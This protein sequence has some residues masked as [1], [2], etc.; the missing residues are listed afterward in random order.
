MADE[1]ETLSNSTADE[2]SVKNNE[3]DQLEALKET[4]KEKLNAVNGSGSDN[5][6]GD[7]QVTNG[8]NEEPKNGKENEENNSSVTAENE[9]TAE[10]DEDEI[11]EED[12]DGGG[13]SSQVSTDEVDDDEDDDDEN[14][15]ES[16]DE[17]DENEDD[18]EIQEVR[19]SGDS[20]D[21]DVMEVEAEDPLQSSMPSKPAS[22]T[23]TEVKKPQVVTIDD[24]KALQALA[25]SAA[26]SK[27]KE[28]DKVTIIDTSVIL[29]GRSTSGVT[30]TPASV[31]SNHKSPA[32]ASALPR[33]LASALQASGVTISSKSSSPTPAPASKAASS[34]ATPPGTTA[35]PGSNFVYDSKGQL[36]DPNLTDDTIVIE[37]P[38]FIV[39]YVYEK[40]PRESFDEFKACIKK[41][42]DE[43]KAKLK[44]E[45]DAKSEEKK[46]EEEKEREA[47]K[48]EK[49]KKKEEKRAK[50]KAKED[51]DSGEEDNGERDSDDDFEESDDSVDSDDSDIVEVDKSRATSPDLPPVKKPNEKFFE[52]TLGK[53]VMD[54]GMNLVQ[55]VVQVDLLRQQQRKAKK[56]K[57]AAVMHAIMSLKQNI[58][59]SKDKNAVF[60]M[61]EKKCKLCSFRTESDLALQHHLETPHMKHG[62]LRCNFCHY[63]T[64]SAQEIVAHMQGFH[65]VKARLE[66][67]PAIHQCPQC[68]FEDMMKGK[69]TRHKVGCDKRFKPERNCE[70]PHDFEPP[71]KIPK[72]PAQ[73]NARGGAASSVSVLNSQGRLLNQGVV[74]GALQQFNQQK[75]LYSAMPTLQF[76]PGRGRPANFSKPFLPNQPSAAQRQ[77]NL[78][79]FGQMGRLAGN[80][81]VTIQV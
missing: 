56:D 22:V 20:S 29:A 49:K 60:H 39:P 26:R 28:K 61:E 48:A 17:N 38:S 44:E 73:Y 69:L 25:S 14:E 10:D 15:G 11:M 75:N 57:S 62:M 80:P 52:S 13:K 35:V 19:D 33:S 8:H 40:P 3:N 66:R 51:R 31:H 55:E 59:Q 5:S 81:S 4:A 63:E 50:K 72:P 43:I 24:P 46:A 27:A 53:M 47:K 41:M 2:L 9:D 36:Q 54:M 23:S 7:S 65:E 42:M 58:E 45:E 77:M 21:S 32:S 78:P 74:K 71:A 18:D 30:I 64:K 67:A 76:G 34:T 37:A 16:D 79:P 12:F 68:L 6:N 70:P 1:T